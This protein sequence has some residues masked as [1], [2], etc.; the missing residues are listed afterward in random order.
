M[1]AASG[2]VVLLSSL[3]T[4]VPA[5]PGGR[6]LERDRWGRAVHDDRGNPQSY[7]T[8]A[9][10][11]RRPAASRVSRRAEPEGAVPP[12]DL[13]LLWSR[14]V[15]GTGIG[16]SGLAVVDLDANGD[17]EVVASSSSLGDFWTNDS[18]LV[19]KFL[20]TGGPAFYDLAWH[21]PVA[22]PTLTALRVAQLDAD[23]QLE[24]VV[25][26]GSELR[27]YDG[28]TRTAQQTVNTAASEINGLVV[29]NAD[30]DPALE[31]ALCSDSTVYIYGAGGALEYSTALPCQDLAVGQVDL[32]PAPEIV[33]GNGDSPGYV[34][35]GV[36]HA[37]QWTNSLGFGIYVRL[38]DLDADG[39]AEVVA[40]SAWYAIRVFDVDL[41]SLTD[42]VSVDLDIGALE[43]LDV[44]GDGSVEIVYGDGQWGEIHVLDGATR[45]Q[46]WQVTNPEHGVTGIAVGDSDADGVR[47]LLWGA[48]YSSTGEDHL[49]VVDT[50]TRAVEWQSA[51]V[52][53]P[54]MALDASRSVGHGKIAVIAA[55]FE[56][57]SGYGDGLYF[58]MR[59]Q[60]G[61]PYYASPPLT[62]LNWTGMTRIRAAELDADSQ[63]E[64]IV[65]TS[66]TYTGL[67]I[68][69]DSLTHAE[70]WRATLPDGLTVASLAL[71]DVDLDGKLEAVVGVEVQH[72]GAPGVYV[73][74]FDAATGVE[75]W[76][77]PSIVSGFV[78]LPWLRLAQV[79]ADPQLDI[80][81]GATNGQIYI[82]D[83]V[84]HTTRSLGDE[85][86]SAIET[87]D[88][89]DNGVAE[90]LVGTS[91]GAVR[92]VDVTTGAILQTLF[93]EAAAIDSL[94]AGDLDGDLVPD[95]VTASGNAVRVHSGVTTSVLWSS[96]VLAQTPSV[97]GSRDSLLLKDV[98]GLP[99]LDLVV[100]LGRAGI[101]VYTTSP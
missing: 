67:L 29:T 55:S 93:T 60:T 23:P 57:D 82:L 85:E 8:R 49:Y 45:L 50:M 26:V 58:F 79:D 31:F 25:A 74:V 83:A 37:L 81:V 54:F 10:E 15:Y 65:A 98:D 90:L 52:R 13:R 91:G 59:A 36:S 34:V 9:F 16:A 30:A 39:R 3:A 76:R 32:D 77:S 42:S 35:D 101:T 84:T 99:G 63:V 27:I 41:Q 6:D 14:W 89:D 51:D 33:I 28:L 88:L 75:E 21:S 96:G 17:T 56:S 43:L 20:P 7:T 86:V 38:A 73:Y 18:W 97:V 5:G 72:T 46:K 24:V 11:P 78:D 68:C 80:V 12:L 44:E 40:G 47:E 66:T 19:A 92:R 48:G 61:T 53:G 87:V 4:A 69:R 95:Y 62:G 1:R 100:N 71:A 64:V 70:Q 2:F 22:T 94:V